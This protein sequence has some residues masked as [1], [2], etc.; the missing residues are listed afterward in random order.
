M[1]LQRPK[2]I[3]AIERLNREAFPEEERIPVGDLVSMARQDGYEL[4]AAYEEERFVGFVFLALAGASIYLFLLAVEPE[5]RS[6]GYGGRIVQKI[7]ERY[8]AG[9]VVA[10]IQRTDEVCDNLQ[11]RVKRRAFYLNQGFHPTGCRLVFHGLEFDILCSRPEFD[12]RS[13]QRVLEDM[14]QNG[15]LLGLRETGPGTGL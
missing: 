12:R 4:L 11:Q 9:Q 14:N 2:D 5:L 6:R 10:D 7:L 3:T 1:I 8:P 13:F 15:F